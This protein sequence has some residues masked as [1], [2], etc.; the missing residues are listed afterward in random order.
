MYYNFILFEDL[1]LVSDI[2]IL[3]YNL[4]FGGFIEI[5]KDM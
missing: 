2:L 4:C 3:K 1:H 5:S